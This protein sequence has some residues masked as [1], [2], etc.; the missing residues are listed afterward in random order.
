MRRLV[1]ALTS[2]TA[3]GSPSAEMLD[4]DGS[5]SGSS[6]SDSSGDSAASLTS[7]TA[8]TTSPGTTGSMTTTSVT[9]IDEDSSTGDPDTTAGSTGE[10]PPGAV[11]CPCDI[12]S[13]CDGELLCVEGTCVGM[14]ACE[15]PEGEPNDDEASA[16]ALDEAQCGA[17]AMMVGGGFDGAESD[18]F[19]Y[20]ANDGIACFD[21]PDVSVTSDTD[22]AVCLYVDCDN[23]QTN[24]NCSGGSQDDMSP[25][26]LDGCCDQNA[27]SL[28]DFGCG[29]SAK[30]AT[31]FVRLTSID[32][33]C[34]PY[35]LSFDY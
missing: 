28:G 6:G 13:T 5:S 11:N 18:W 1:L 29:I 17:A 26:G 3:C 34:L 22:V 21:N 2:C 33:A 16:V 14:P 30:N 4:T 19:T 12:G 15:E 24:V 7:T 10:C 35:E 23:G 27:L 32:A 31:I 8:M 25:D 9:T 20:H